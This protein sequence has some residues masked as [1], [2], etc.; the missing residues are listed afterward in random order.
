MSPIRLF[1]TTLGVAALASTGCGDDDGGGTDAGCASPRLADVRPASMCVEPGG[2]LR[3]TVDGCFCGTTLA[4]EATVTGDTLSFTTRS[5]ACGTTMC[6]DCTPLVG[7][8]HVPAGLAASH[9]Y[10]VEIDGELAFDFTTDSAGAL[11]AD[12][13]FDPADS[14]PRGFTCTNDRVAL[15][16]ATAACIPAYARSGSSVYVSATACVPC[17]ATEAGCDVVRADGPALHVTAWYRGCDCASCGACAGPCEDRTFACAL[18][19]LDNGT[20]YAVDIGGRSAVIS[21]SATGTGNTDC[22]TP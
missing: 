14:V 21:V 10:A 3:V 8:C 17:F 5:V 16:T 9:R 6:P 18:P 19:P 12:T 4:C 1:A 7:E 2:V 22:A 13:C 20:A 11:P 15:E